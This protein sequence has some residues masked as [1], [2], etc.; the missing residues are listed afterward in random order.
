MVAGYET[1]AEEQDLP[2]PDDR[3]VLAAALT[4]GAALLV[5]A[6]LDDFPAEQMPTGLSVVSPDGLVLEL[7]NDDLEPWWKSSRLRPLR[8]PTHP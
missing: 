5:T 4:A 2:D 6:N 3:H 8:S 1:L 7:M